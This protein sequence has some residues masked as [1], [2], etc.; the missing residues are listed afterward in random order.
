MQSASKLKS[1]SRQCG[2]PAVAAFSV[3]VCTDA[4]A[5]NL[6]AGKSAVRLF[7]DSC[8]TC[9]RSPRGLAKGRY[10][11]TLFAFLRDHYSA[12]SGAA[13]ELASYLASV[14]TPQRGRVAR[15]SGQ[16][17]SRCEFDTE[18][19]NSTASAGPAALIFA[20]AG[21]SVNRVSPSRDTIN[22]RQV[23]RCEAGVVLLKLGTTTRRLNSPSL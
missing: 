10:R 22:P 16:F 20:P 7:A 11:V 14:D 2:L 15:R 3:L 17:I 12:T 9:H 21:G 18:V 4:S 6:D 5:Q 19:L 23:E 8:V 1:L 13:W